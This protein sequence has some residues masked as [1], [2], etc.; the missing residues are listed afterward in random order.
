MAH[1]LAAVDTG[2]MFAED[3]PQLHPLDDA[4]EQWQ[5]PDVI[6]TEV[7]GR[8]PE[9]VCL[10]GL[11]V[12]SGVARETSDRGRVSVRALRITPRMASG[13]RRTCDQ[14]TKRGEGSSRRESFCR[15]YVIGVMTIT[16]DVSWVELDLRH[17]HKI[18][19]I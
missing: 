4:L 3:A 7:G 14:G 6:G 18:W 8:R 11:A 1:S 10:G 9:R 5:G 17:K 16:F 2:E 12:W 13:N 19:L 15:D